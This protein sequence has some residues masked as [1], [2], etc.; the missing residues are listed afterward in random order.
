MVSTSYIQ[1]PK[2]DTWVGK[3]AA[4]ASLVALVYATKIMCTVAHDVGVVVV[5]STVA[6]VAVAVCEIEAPKS[7][8]ITS[9]TR[10]SIAQSEVVQRG[11]VFEYQISRN[12]ANSWAQ[13]RVLKVHH[14]D[15]P[16][17]FT[18][19][20]DNCRERQISDRKR[21]RWLS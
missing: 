20:M 15:L 21:M 7:N 11:D 12:E 1:L 18:V 13:V 3:V 9:D 16:P 19:L 14:D 6:Y 4:S 17:Y 10:R 5:A 2:T 8:G